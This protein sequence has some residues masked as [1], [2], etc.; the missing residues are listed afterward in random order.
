MRRELKCAGCGES[1]IIEGD[2]FYLGY[3]SAMCPSCCRGF[4]HPGSSD[5]AV[6]TGIT[7]ANVRAIVREELANARTDDEKKKTPRYAW[8][9]RR[10]GMDFESTS[11]GLTDIIRHAIHTHFRDPS[12]CVEMVNVI[13]GERVEGF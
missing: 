12:Q 1:L 4:A 6:I 3:A 10:C 2:D 5:E 8:R 9:C 11:N 13:T 7:L